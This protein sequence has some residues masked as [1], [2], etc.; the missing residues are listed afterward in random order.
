[1]IEYL[2]S[3]LIVSGLA[4]AFRRVCWVGDPPDWPADLPVAIYANHHG[5]YDGHLLWYAV[6]RG[7]DRSLILWMEEWDR[8]PLFAPCGAVPFPSDDPARRV[9]TIRRTAARMAQDPRTTLTYFPEGR[10]HAPEEGLL[11]FPDGVFAR[12]DRLFPAKLWAPVALHV[13]WWGDS[14]P[15][16]LLHAGTPHATSSGDERDRL[17][18]LWAPLRA[19][20][21]AH[22]TL[23]F[24][25]RRG[26]NE[27]RD[28]RMTRTF[29]SR[30][31]R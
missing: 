7:L 26:P 11:A 21:P 19:A 28:F 17:E 1:M 22:T 20:R 27:G 24:E 2:V 18:A 16:A 3:R 4:S 23:L 14:L 6:E 15:T 10:L 5:F 30:Y 13:T 9:A 29:F 12:L 8:F 25:G 31:I